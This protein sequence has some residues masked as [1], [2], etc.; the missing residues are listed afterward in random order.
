M[1]S[2]NRTLFPRRVPVDEPPPLSGQIIGSRRTPIYVLA[3]VCHERDFFKNLGS[4]EDDYRD[5]VSDKWDPPSSAG[6]G[7]TTSAGPIMLPKM[8]PS[9]QQ[10]R[11]GCG[12]RPG[13]L[14]WFRWPLSWL[15]DEECQRNERERRAAE[16]KRR[17]IR[18]KLPGEV[19]ATYRRPGSI[20]GSRSC[21]NFSN[22]SPWI[23][24]R[25][26]GTVTDFSILFCQIDTQKNV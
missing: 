5:L 21:L 20:N 4:G 22:R 8:L 10:G 25:R 15:E 9:T 18:I 19:V 14:Q 6:D 23:W 12:P 1:M 26:T 17:R 2:T 16:R 7:W 13:A 24:K 3:W 11:D